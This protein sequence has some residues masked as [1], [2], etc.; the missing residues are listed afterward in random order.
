MAPSVG[1][2]PSVPEALGSIPAPN[3]TI[4]TGV[5]RLQ[6]LQERGRR[7]DQKVKVI[8]SYKVRLRAARGTQDS[9][10]VES[11]VES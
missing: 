4:L 1:Y 8:F 10:K 7:E 6:S 2:L 5:A 3:K 11:T 9:L